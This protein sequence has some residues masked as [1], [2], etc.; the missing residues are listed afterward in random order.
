[1]TDEQLGD[2][3]FGEQKSDEERG[4]ELLEDALA[5]FDSRTEV[6]VA[7]REAM[8][9]LFAE[10]VHTP[11]APAW[12]NGDD[13]TDWLDAR[14]YDGDY[15]IVGRVFREKHWH[16]VDEVKSRIPRRH[17]RPIKCWAPKQ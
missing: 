6:I 2:A 7:I 15:R 9:K 12:V 5:L 11:G 14:K 1:M 16:L 17:R 10:R 4:E 8:I 3:L 13:A